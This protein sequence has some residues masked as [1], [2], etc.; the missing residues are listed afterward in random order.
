MAAFVMRGLAKL[1][2][3]RVQI[4]KGIDHV[5]LNV[6]GTLPS[7]PDGYPIGASAEHQGTPVRTGTKRKNLI[8][9][10]DLGSFRRKNATQICAGGKEISPSVQLP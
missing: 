1:I 6:A 9:I 7:D 10:R 3:G 4:P 2:V 8:F 5:T